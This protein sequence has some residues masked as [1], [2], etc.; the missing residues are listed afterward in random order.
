TKVDEHFFPE[1]RHM[2]PT[3]LDCLKSGELA[4]PLAESDD[5]QLASVL[6]ALCG[7]LVY[8]RSMTAARHALFFLG[9]KGSDKWLG[10]ISA[11]SASPGGFQGS[12]QAINVDGQSLTVTLCE[13]TPTNAAALRG[14]FDFLVPRPLGLKKSAGCG[15]RL[16]LATPGHIRAIRRSSMAPILAQQSIRENARTGR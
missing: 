5:S 10:I 14:I 6:S 12:P 8:P 4:A 2:N 13:T 15:D 7:T 16:G 3:L 9:R 1:N 11:A